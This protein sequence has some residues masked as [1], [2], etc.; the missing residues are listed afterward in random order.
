M[1]LEGRC[2]F[3][4][5]LIWTL[6]I[7]MCPLRKTCCG[8]SFVVLRKRRL[9]DLK[10]SEV[11]FWKTVLFIFSY[12]FQ[13]SLKL[14]TLPCLWKDSVIVPVPKIKF[15]KTLRLQTSCTYVSCDE[16]KKCSCRLYSISWTSSSLLT[17]H[18]EVWR[19]QQGL[20]WTP[21]GS[22]VLGWSTF[23][24]LLLSV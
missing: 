14:H 19:M 9:P 8:N 13:L 6:Y 1:V 15:P 22:Q 5:M 17:G 23:H 20:F 18:S 2:L 3:W 21:W 24:Q 16:Q 11:G 12:I 7:M 4:G 10:V